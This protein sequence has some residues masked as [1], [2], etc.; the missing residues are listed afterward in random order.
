MDLARLH[1]LL[2]DASLADLRSRLRRH[3]EHRDQPTTIK[4]ARLAS[5]EREA[6]AALVG[7]PPRLSAS[8]TLDLAQVDATLQAAG[9]ASSL[10]AALEQLDGPLGPGPSERAETLAAWPRLVSE[11]SHPLLRHGLDQPATLGQLKRLARQ[12]LGLARQLCGQAATVLQALPGQGQ[13]RARL[14]AQILGDAHALDDGQPVATLVL[15]VL[16]Q[17]AGVIADS[18]NR[19]LW[20]GAGIS[21]NELARP[22]LTLNLGPVGEPTYWSLRHLLRQAHPWPVAGRT[23]FVCENPNLVAIAADELGA[24][25]APLVCTDGM[26]GAAQRTLLTQLARAGALL[27]YHGDFDWPGI[28]IANHVLA[29]HGAAPWRMSA[30][31][32]W[33]AT[34]WVPPAPLQGT[35]VEASWDVELAAAMQAARQAVAEESL[36]DSLLGDLAPPG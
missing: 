24:A 2:G 17:G 31:D 20:A 13:P 23:V 30:Q 15:C 14:A 19:S 12:D 35:A 33:Q 16:R 26:P 34:R 6:L 27:R 5:H 11:I 22:V 18:S 4:L 10:R 29:I 28:G 25:C 8:I 7:R 36:V 32:Y 1:S 21:V 9:V 3:I